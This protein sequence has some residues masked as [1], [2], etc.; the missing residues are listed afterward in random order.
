VN[1]PDSVPAEIEQDDKV[2]RL[3][4]AVSRHVVPAKPEPEAVTTVPTRP[5]VGLNVSVGAPGTVKGSVATSPTGVPVTMR[6]YVPLA[7]DATVNE[8]D[9]AVADTVHSGLGLEEMR[10][11]GDDEIVQPVS[12][13]A[14]FVPVTRTI[15]P[16][17]PVVGV[18]EMP[19]VSVKVVLPTSV[20][21]PVTSTVDEPGATPVSTGKEPVTVPPTT[22]QVS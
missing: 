19:G 16:A 8:P 9:I 6:V 1:P 18:T 7:P 12:V 3:P 5:V 10:P 17:R 11:L 13:G 20:S 15:C 22:S 2:K 4:G 14:K 21:V